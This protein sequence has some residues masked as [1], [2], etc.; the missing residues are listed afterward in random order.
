MS[1]SF[2]ASLKSELNKCC[3]WS[4][5]STAEVTTLAEMLPQQLSPNASILSRSKGW[6][7]SMRASFR[8]FRSESPT[9][10]HQSKM[11]TSYFVQNKQKLKNSIT[12][13]NSEARNLQLGDL[14][15]TGSLNSGTQQ[16][17]I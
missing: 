10:Q 8:S 12:S 2:R 6:R 11:L 15:R 9:D 1:E 13:N 14:E 5:S 16:I 3:C 4:D 17:V 7:H